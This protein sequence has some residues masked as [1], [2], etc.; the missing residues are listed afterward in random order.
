VGCQILYT[1][2]PGTSLDRI[3]NRVGC[4]AIISSC[5]IL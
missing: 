2:L 5:S 3:P 4:H 1:S